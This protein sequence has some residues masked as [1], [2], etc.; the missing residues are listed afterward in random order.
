MPK[1]V[2]CMRA[3]DAVETRMSKFT[4]RL[5]DELVEVFTQ[6][7]HQKL[8]MGLTSEFPALQPIGAQTWVC[9]EAGVD[10]HH[11]SVEIDGTI[12]PVIPADTLVRCRDYRWFII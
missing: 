6:A 7:V 11:M 3:Y 10:C 9:D 8:W 12:S 2:A 4:D 5:S 1:I